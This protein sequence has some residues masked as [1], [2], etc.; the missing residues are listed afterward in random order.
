[1]QVQNCAFWGV[2]LL[3]L[4]LGGCGGAIDANGRDI[5]DAGG[6][7]PDAD[8][9]VHVAPEPTDAASDADGGAQVTKVPMNH[10]AV[11]AACTEP[12]S[13]VNAN[14]LSCSP[15]LCG[16]DGGCQGDL[17][18][19][20]GTNGRCVC[21]FVASSP[22]C[23]AEARCSY[24][25]CQ[26]D[27]D[28]G[29]GIVSD[30]VQSRGVCACRGSLPDAGDLSSATVCLFGNCQTDADC[31]AGGYCSP[32]PVPGCG[33]TWWHGYFCHTPRDEC[34]NNADCP[35]GNA[36]CAFNSDHWICS[37]GMCPDG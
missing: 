9:T 18:C 29:N 13:A 2:A 7:R 28:C 32:S 17:A 37:T 26:S 30:G 14:P 1:M 16:D 25:A 8:A 23:Y 24:D 31:G 6:A 20:A 10:R 11:A 5:T 15:P 12:R 36:Y 21:A 4:T 34:A 27:S 19:P 3:G 33:A 35:Q 22:F